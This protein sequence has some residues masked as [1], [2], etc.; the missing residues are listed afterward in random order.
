MI[1]ALNDTC[2]QLYESSL[3]CFPSVALTWRDFLESELNVSRS[4]KALHV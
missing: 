4:E 3:H 1:A 2:W